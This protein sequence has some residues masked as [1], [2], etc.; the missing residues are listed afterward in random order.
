MVLKYT[1]NTGAPWAKKP[2]GIPER[3]SVIKIREN[4]AVTPWAE[5]RKLNRISY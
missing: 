1:T 2:R 4:P 5:F 3:N